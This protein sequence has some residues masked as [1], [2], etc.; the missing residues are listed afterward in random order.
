MDIFNYNEKTKRTNPLKTS[1]KL[2]S[3][4]DNIRKLSDNIKKLE[5][6]RI[7]KKVKQKMEKE[8]IKFDAKKLPKSAMVPLGE[9]DKDGAGISDMVQRQLDTAHC[10][11]IMNPD[12]YQ[13]ALSQSIYAIKRSDG[14]WQCIDGQHT[15]TVLATFVNNGLM[16]H[17]GPWQTLEHP[18]LYVETDSVAFA[19]R[20][21]S[22]I[23]GKGK[24]AISK[25]K[26]LEN[27]V[28]IV[29]VCNDTSDPEDVKNEKRVR[30]A[31]DNDCYAVEQNTS[32]SEDAG[33]FT[34]ISSFK[35][36]SE[37]VIKKTTAW[38]DKYYHFMP[39]DGALWF[40]MPDL[41]NTFKNHDIK[42]TDE[43]LEEIAGM[44]DNIFGDYQIYHNKMKTAYN[45]FTES[46]HGKALNWRDD[47]LAIGLVQLYKRL[48]GEADVPQV[49]LDEYND[50][51]N[52]NEGTIIDHLPES[53]TD[54]F[55]A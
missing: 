48:G 49:M 27:S 52:E 26:E 14:T 6:G 30:I 32:E 20:A 16:E 40:F 53:V 31:Q 47:C 39:V 9:F 21:F 50:Y 15:I 46:K 5:N 7:F 12:T 24:K 13:E 44:I 45:K 38:H 41:I 28:Q 3:T 2:D 37:S 33:A 42:L 55:N 8:G 34:H 22:L 54:R 36:L 25:Y 19:L 17:D 23:N 43:F 29:R 11:N 35:G 4:T 51:S 18:C 10:G 1:Y